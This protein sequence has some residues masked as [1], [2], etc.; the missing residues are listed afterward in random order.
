MKRDYLLLHL[1]VFLA[2]FTGVLGRLIALNEAVLVWYRMALSAL[3]L[4]GFLATTK[5]FQRVDFKEIIKIAGTGVLL[6]F[7]WVFFY[8]SIKASNVSI[9]VV[10]FSL[11][12]F[13]TALFEPIINRHQFSIAQFLLS[14]LTLAGVY[15]IFQFDA[16]YRLGIAMGLVSSALYSLF[17][18]SNQRI[19][20][21]HDA[22]MMLFWELIGG[23]IALSAV[24]PL[25]LHFVPTDKFLPDG[26]DWCYMAFM[27]LVCTIGLYLLQIIALQRIPAFTVNLTYNLEPVYSILLSLLIFQEHKD[28]N[29]SFGIGIA[30]I[31]LS[32][33]LQTISE[34][35]K[36]HVS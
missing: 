32:V 2:G 23:L 1:S 26:M 35:K 31:I 20:R 30:L 11:V 9:G 13:F 33:V 36:T 16:R 6:S 4:L 27:V 12:C 8:G 22:K 29:F 24:M 3:V 10:C 34:W 28:L 15:C 21:Q 17:A 7:H 18:I 5:Q 25:Y 14:F 19:G